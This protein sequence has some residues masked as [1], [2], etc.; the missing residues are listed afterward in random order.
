MGAKLKDKAVRTMSSFSRRQAR[1]GSTAIP[2]RERIS[3]LQLSLLV[4]SE[5]PDLNHVHR[6]LKKLQADNPFTLTSEIRFLADKLLHRA[7]ETQQIS[8]WHRIEMMIGLPGARFGDSA[9]Q[10]NIAPILSGISDCLS[11][12]LGSF[13]KVGPI[14]EE[15]IGFIIRHTHAA[16]ARSSACRQSLNHCDIR[17]ENQVRS[18]VLAL[19]KLSEKIEKLKDRV[20]TERIESCLR[21]TSQL[22]EK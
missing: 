4:S 1:P 7:L 20:V 18:G 2:R 13:E 22:L 15:L 11:S 3:E 5:P 6:L 10:G 16:F 21:R 14:E 9:F 19:H 17:A 8:Q 12:S